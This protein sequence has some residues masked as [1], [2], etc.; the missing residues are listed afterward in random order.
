M[1]RQGLLNEKTQGRPSPTNMRWFPYIGI[2]KPMDTPLV[3]E[4]LLDA[5]AVGFFEYG[6]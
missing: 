2:F 6:S 1:P 3:T 5:S 4:M